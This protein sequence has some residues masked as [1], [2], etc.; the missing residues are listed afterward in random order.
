[1]ASVFGDPR[2]L[3]EEEA[4]EDSVLR[5]MA[6]RQQVRASLP[7][8][9]LGQRFGVLAGAPAFDAKRVPVGLQQLG[10]LL[11]E[12]SA[13][14]QLGPEARQ[15]WLRSFDHHVLSG[16]EQLIELMNALLARHN[17]LPGLSYVPLRKRPRAQERKPS[18]PAGA[19]RDPVRNE[20]IALD[21]RQAPHTG[22]MGDA[23]KNDPAAESD[24]F[25][26]LQ[27]LLAERRNPNGAS[28]RRSPFA[29]HS[30]PATCR[31]E[32][33]SAVLQVGANHNRSRRDCSS[34]NSSGAELH[35]T[36]RR[37]W[38]SRHGVP[39]RP[40]RRGGSARDESLLIRA[41]TPPA[42]ARAS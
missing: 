32:L 23:E 25:D 16:Y 31:A 27:Q 15:S 12:A 5:A 20:P 30:P 7:L 1:M 11:Q 3:D 22:W 29:A 14:V 36:G 37:T 26:T 2:L 19:S 34:R 4:S 40:S 24:A 13:V 6:V 8:Q 42:P 28:A 10:R 33:C 38:A 39:S 17:V 41:G 9:L 35:S 18:A 21:P